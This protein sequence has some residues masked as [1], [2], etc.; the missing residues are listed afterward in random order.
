M[1]YEAKPD[2]GTLFAQKNKTSDKSPDL[3]GDIILSDTLVAEL[4][5]LVND[6]KPAKIRLAA[7][8]KT[9]KDGSKFL[10]LKASP[11]VFAK[12]GAPSRSRAS[13][14]DLPF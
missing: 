5:K 1:A 9:T 8:T 12:T 7:W 2:S 10:S 11:S 3:T 6:R 4:A 13:D 14:D